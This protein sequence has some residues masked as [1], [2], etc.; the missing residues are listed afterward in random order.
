MRCKQIEISA[1]EY[2]TDCAKASKDSSALR[3]HLYTRGLLQ[4]RHS[5]IT[6]LAFGERYNLHRLILDQSPFF[7]KA[8][9]GP[10]LESNAQEIKLHPE[11]TDT[12]ITQIGFE[13]TLKHLY[14]CDISQE[15]DEEA[16]GLFATG[17][18]L[19]LHAIIDASVKSIIAQ[20]EP[21]NLAH[22]ICLFTFNEYGRPGQKVLNSAKAMLFSHGWEMP[23]KFWDGIPGE[24]I[25]EIVGGDSFYVYTEW[26]R[27]VLAKRLLDR[28]LRDHAYELGLIARGA[29]QITQAPCLPSL[30]AIRSGHASGG[31]TTSGNQN[32]TTVHKQWKALYTDPD[33]E[34]L[35]VLLDEG[36][37]YMHFE[38]EQLEFIKRSQDV[39]GLPVVP[40]NT[41]SSA[42]WKQLVLRQR[43]IGAND[44]QEELGI[45]RLQETLEFETTQ[46][47]TGTSSK[48]GR[49]TYCKTDESGSDQGPRTWDADG[50][51]RKFWIPIADAMAFYGDSTDQ[52]EEPS[53]SSHGGSGRGSML[54]EV[55]ESEWTR[56]STSP[57]NSIPPGATNRKSRNQPRYTEFPPFRFCVELPHPRFLQEKNKIYSRTMSYAGSLWNIYIQ[58]LQSTG[59]VQLGI[60]LHRT[61]EENGKSATGPGG[62]WGEKR[63]T[64]RDIDAAYR[65]LNWK[66]LK[67]HY[68]PPDTRKYLS[69]PNSA[70]LS[71][72]DTDGSSRAG[73]QEHYRHSAEELRDHPRQTILAKHDTVGSYKS[74][75]SV[76]SSTSSLSRSTLQMP[77]SGEHLD[78]SQ[79][80][81]IS[82]S[83]PTTADA[84]SE[85]DD[86]DPRISYPDPTNSKSKACLP[87]YID[88]RPTVRTYFK[89]FSPSKGGR[90][91]NVF[92]SAPDTFNFSQSWGW[93]STTLMSDDSAEQ[94]EEVVEGG[95]DNTGPSSSAHDVDPPKLRFMVI[96]GN[97]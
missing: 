64:E 94:P 10:W 49:V 66:R 76:H 35:L 79:A 1:D 68:H 90:M 46:I 62:R 45:S 19:E 25:K 95:K 28:R 48:N 24:I 93:K 22:L 34:P 72:D 40:E 74:R 84:A 87:A 71:G 58:K 17:S 53:R 12:N 60:Y 2:V 61:N 70:R 80:E 54:I 29:K 91:L 41:L 3:N 5:D 36:I 32:K 27:W 43:V 82:T 50:K 81:A 8:L 51:P 86:D 26:D 89:I 96:I 39:F 16:I 31:V 55:D 21:S 92:E 47:S 38:F 7:C 37:H 75:H 59:N 67:R 77:S 33:I 78:L 44:K 23:L 88:N 69:N 65:R 42:L 20:M 73:A 9:S 97:L 56:E 18:W 11:G 57:L 4:G 30:T 15:V 63:E 6:V 83:S 13:I 14:G 52:P 85:S